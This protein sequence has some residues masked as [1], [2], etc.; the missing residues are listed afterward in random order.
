VKRL[1]P[2]TLDG[3]KSIEELVYRL[4]KNPI[5]ERLCRT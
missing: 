2:E 5:I 1:K 4:R 3:R